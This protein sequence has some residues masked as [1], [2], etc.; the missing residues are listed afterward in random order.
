MMR[1]SLYFI[2]LG[3]FQVTASVHAQ[4]KVNLNM[5]QGTL[6]DVIW[7]L[8]KQT[9]IV[10]IYTTS[11]V[12]HVPV[13][14]LSVKQKEVPE[15][16]DICLKNSGLT[17]EVA[18]GDVIVIKKKS[19]SPSQQL[20]SVAAKGIVTDKDGLTIP[21]VSIVIKG[22]SLGVVTDMNGTF[23]LN[24]PDNIK[25]PVLIF[26]FVGMKKQEI[27]FKGQDLKVVME[28]ESAELNEVVVTGLFDRP[29]ESY[30]GAVKVITSKDLQAA[31]NRSILSSI[32]NVDPSFNIVEDI[33]IGSDPNKL[34][35]ITIR[36]NSSLAVQFS[37]VVEDGITN[38]VA[39]TQSVNE[40]N[41]PL[42]IM[43]G[44][45]I[46]L[47]RLMD[48]DDS[49]VENITILKDAG[50]TA[51]YGSRGANGVVVITSKRPQSG[52]LFLSY[53][54]NFNFEA[55]DLSSYNLLNATEKLIFEK[56]A[57]LYVGDNAQLTQQ[58]EDL[59]NERRID[60]ERGVNTD[61]LHYPVR[62]GFGM[63]HSLRLEGGENAIRYHA[64]ISYD[65]IRGAM[66][67][68]ERNTL[69]GEILLSYRTKKL[70][71]QNKLQVSSNKA[72]N[73]PYGSFSDYGKLNA[74]WAPYDE[75]G[76]LKKML[77]NATYKGTGVLRRTVNKGNPLYNALLPGKNTSEYLQVYNYFSV[78]W[79]VNTE[80][81]IRGRL[82]I[83]A[84]RNQ[85]DVFVPPGNTE[86]DNLPE[87]DQDRKGRYTYS[88]GKGSGYSLNLSLNYT[89]N[90]HEKH[91]VYSTLSFDLRNDESESYT[92]VAEGIAL[93]NMDFLG[94]A[95]HYKKDGSPGGSESVTRSVGVVA[96]I[97]YTYDARLFADI[98]F[99]TDGSSQF[100]ANKRFAPFWST[101]IGWNLHRENFFKP[102]D[103]IDYARF[104]LSYGTSGAQSF[105]SFQS[106]T[107][108]QNDQS[109]SY[110]GWYGVNIMGL[111]NPDLGWQTT[112]EWNLG[113]EIELFKKR[114][115]LNLD[116]YF[117]NT[118]N[119]LTDVNLPW[120]SG[121]KNYRANV[122][123]MENRGVEA[124]LT[125]YVIRN[126][127][128]DINWTIG[129]QTRHNKNEITKI[130]N[131]LK[132]LNDK[133]EGSNNRNPS[134]LFK[135][136]ESYNTI[137]AV[138]SKGIDPATGKEIFITRHGTET[139]DWDSKDQVPCGINEP[140]FFGNI[141]TMFQY[142]GLTFNAILRYRF[143]GQ[144]YNYTLVNKVENI[145]PDDNAD[146][147]V[148]YDRWEKPGD[149]AFFKSRYDRSETRA[150]SRFVMDENTLECSSVNLGYTFP[151]TFVKKLA[152]SSLTITG[153]MEDVFRISTIK[154]ERGWDY[155][156]ARKFSLSISA[157]F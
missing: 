156:F 78:D 67:G 154:Q 79:N 20:Q 103:Y 13:S 116:V 76:N 32:R 57:G 127:E 62:V 60:A 26:S 70:T 145:N 137:F 27:L 155:P 73:S 44:F 81:I 30:T 80:W 94:M 142:R 7:E 65:N 112:H 28:E 86:F 29:R 33:S 15:V 133:L 59:Y 22:S 4:S 31:G 93:N 35:G 10:F 39:N 43:D 34:P 36:G 69:N 38:L 148:L 102:N 87:S 74:Y 128:K 150:S 113:T 108:Y 75:F 115:R 120:S 63:R 58:L 134:F 68:S 71:F 109:S 72:K 84:I 54:G 92:V 16:L 66:K 125:A 19:L 122:G 8:Q 117:R 136:G 151:T 98:S 18:D 131:S 100:G 105:Q 143:G 157:Q 144:T 89:K 48:M 12:E 14:D 110:R 106:V 41:Q 101:G 3:C 88:T 47:E 24:I 52:R 17:Y 107:S 55:P 9:G 104:R 85:A 129:V 147:R 118:K 6:H 40:V 126:R 132:A 56:G 152:M 114:I 96:N 139:F 46:S 42:F 91:L 97:N 123:S 111:G 130:S 121:F 140:K 21:G 61:W 99:K 82:G 138:K 149:K 146:K 5:K 83:S 95:N 1:L 153:Y 53:R 119:L 90:F 11:D 37:E 23:Q 49:Q 25:D 50:A 2:L 64:G 45:E 141:N 77:D 51:L 135:E 124:S